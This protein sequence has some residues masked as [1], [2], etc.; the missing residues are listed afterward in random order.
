MVE[1]STEPF[2]LVVSVVE[3]LYLDMGADVRLSEYL[4]EVP[5]FGFELCVCGCRA[6]ETGYRLL[7]AREDDQGNSLDL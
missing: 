1:L 7:L 2:E 5:V 4:L 6:P 3:G